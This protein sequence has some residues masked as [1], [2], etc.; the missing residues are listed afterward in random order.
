MS[1]Q[2]HDASEIRARSQALHTKIRRAEEDAAQLRRD[3]EARGGG[4]MIP[5]QIRELEFELDE[6]AGIP[7][8]AAQIL[9]ERALQRERAASP[10]VGA[11]LDGAGPAAP[12]SEVELMSLVY[13]LAGDCDPSD[14]E[15]LRAL[16]ALRY[17]LNRDPDALERLRALRERAGSDEP[18]DLLWTA[19][20]GA[21]KN[22]SKR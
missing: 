10:L 1:I 9:E 13:L 16:P 6:L 3:V 8:A 5:E 7:L 18:D 17:L 19:R 22:P 12:P 11:L 14:V 20:D 15:R 2:P 4:G 21:P